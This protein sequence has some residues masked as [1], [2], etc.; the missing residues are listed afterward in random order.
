M[1][2]C[3]E[4]RLR[5]NQMHPSLQLTSL[6]LKGA[7]VQVQPGHGFDGVLGAA[8]LPL[9]QLELQLCTLLDSE[10]AL[11]AALSHLTGLERLSVS[12]FRHPAP[13]LSPQ[14]EVIC[15]PTVPLKQL[16]QL[17]YLLLDGV[18]LE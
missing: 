17:T 11:T 1:T 16:Q 12:R 10:E 4:T 13:P 15:Y 3:A 18:R 14:P 6:T 2:C 5:L 7:A 9:K 8:G